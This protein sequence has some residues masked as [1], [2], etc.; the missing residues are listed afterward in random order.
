[1]AG[2]HLHAKHARH[3]REGAP[4]ASLD[5]P[6]VLHNGVQSCQVGGHPEIHIPVGAGSLADEGAGGV[7][8]EDVGCQALQPP[9]RGDRIDSARNRWIAFV[10][11]RVDGA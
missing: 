2:E 9:G 4:R 5:I 1:M 11:I 7:E 10:Y 3:E 6:V 8:M